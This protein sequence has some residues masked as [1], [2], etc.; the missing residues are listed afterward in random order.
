MDN[1]S[2]SAK[3]LIVFLVAIFAF[4]VSNCAALLT[5]GFINLDFLDSVEGVNDS[6]NIFQVNKTSKNDSPQSYYNDSNTSN[7]FPKGNT[8]S[9]NNGNNNDN[10]N[11]NDNTE[12]VTEPNPPQDNTQTEAN[13]QNQF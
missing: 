12:P 6:S 2:K 7:E 5:S 1:G 10:S 3:V 8:N 9:N 4:G 11:N 13:N